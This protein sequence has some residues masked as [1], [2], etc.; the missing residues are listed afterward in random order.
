MN[1]TVVPSV[2][3]VARHQDTPWTSSSDTVVS[4][5]GPGTCIIGP[6][7]EGAAVPQR[8]GRE[9][10][11]QLVGTTGVGVQRVD[12][13]EVAELLGH[14]WLGRVG[15]SDRDVEEVAGT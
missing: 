6:V 15:P 7:P 14:R 3:L 5:G 13:D 12:L 11:G 10:L 1:G 2:H 4:S 8:V 9:E